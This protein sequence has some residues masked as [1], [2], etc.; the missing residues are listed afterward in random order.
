MGSLTMRRLKMTMMAPPQGAPAASRGDIIHIGGH[1]LL[2]RLSHLQHV[3]TAPPDV[4]SNMSS[5]LV[6]IP[7]HNSFMRVK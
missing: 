4:N 7:I 1:V 3:F 5:G 6:T 2:V